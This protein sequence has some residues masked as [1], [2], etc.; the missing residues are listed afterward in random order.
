MFLGGREPA[1]EDLLASADDHS[2]QS[3][4]ILHNHS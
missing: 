3:D 1:Y 4:D 2:M